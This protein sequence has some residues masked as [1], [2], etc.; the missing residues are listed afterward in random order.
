LLRH[1]A[2]KPAT[3]STSQ[4]QAAK[5]LKSATQAQAAAQDAAMRQNLN[6]H[7]KFYEIST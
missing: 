7:S 6:N 4:E 3:D 2:P 1:F 5:P